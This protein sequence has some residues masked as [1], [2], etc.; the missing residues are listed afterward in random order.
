MLR[1][2]ST[3]N[4]AVASKSRTKI[5]RDFSIFSHAGALLLKFVQLN[6]FQT[7]FIKSF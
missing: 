1:V 4:D 2:T 7:V 3:S 6:V 5:V